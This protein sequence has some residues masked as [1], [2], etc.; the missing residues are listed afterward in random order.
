GQVGKNIA[1]HISGDDDVETLRIAHDVRHHSVDNY[2]VDRDCRKFLRH[3]VARLDEK[4]IGHFQHVGLVHN[5]NPLAPAHRQFTGNTRDALTAGPRYTTQRDRDVLRYQ[6]FA[7]AGLHVA[8]GIEPFGI[9]ASDD[10]IELAATQ[11][12]T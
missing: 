1:I 3:L 2:V 8:V 6:D 11:R 10:K 9:L 12:E 7:A 5:G 4:T